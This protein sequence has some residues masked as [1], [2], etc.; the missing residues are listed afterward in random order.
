MVDIYDKEMAWLYLFVY[1]YTA[2]NIIV[3]MVYL[4][5]FSLDQPE[6]NDQ[7]QTLI[8]ENPVI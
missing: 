5:G 4:F 6:N 2:T 7:V 3:L 1:I 8:T